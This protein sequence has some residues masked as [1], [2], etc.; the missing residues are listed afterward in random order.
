MIIDDIRSKLLEQFIIFFNEI[1]VGLDILIFNL[2]TI[3][4]LIVNF[5]EIKIYYNL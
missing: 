4:F 3:N 2:K 5:G 1:E